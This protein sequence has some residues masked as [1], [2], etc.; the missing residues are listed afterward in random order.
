MPSYTPCS[1]ATI[2]ALWPKIGTIMSE[3][4]SFTLVVKLSMLG[5]NPVNLAILLQKITLPEAYA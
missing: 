1:V 5:R 2:L 4:T 3:C